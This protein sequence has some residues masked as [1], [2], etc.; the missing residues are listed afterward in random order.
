[1]RTFYLIFMVSLLCVSGPILAQQERDFQEQTLPPKEEVASFHID[2]LT[3]QGICSSTIPLWE[4]TGYTWLGRG[5]EAYVDG[6][7]SGASAAAYNLLTTSPNLKTLADNCCQALGYDLWY[8]PT[9]I[10]TATWLGP[11]PSNSG[12]NV[13]T[14]A[15]V[16]FLACIKHGDDS[17]L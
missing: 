12:W 7:Q 3:Q 9:Q 17:R 14:G 15:A 16:P 6:G 13:S 4:G 2:T 10:N 5:L 1:M 8:G 11:V